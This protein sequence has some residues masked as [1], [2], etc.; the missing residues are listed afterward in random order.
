M[1]ALWAGWEPAA[2][3]SQL[4]EQLVGRRWLHAEHAA[5]QFSGWSP[6]GCGHHVV[7]GVG[8]PAT[9]RR[10]GTG[11]GAWAARVIGMRAR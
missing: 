4:G 1:L 8:L 6:R 2:A 10:S 3:P 11:R 7:D 9:S 5:T